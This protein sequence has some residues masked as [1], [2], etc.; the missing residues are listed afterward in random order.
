MKIE[1]TALINRSQGFGQFSEQVLEE[2]IATILRV[3]ISN[4][5]CTTRGIR[6]S[7]QMAYQC[8]DTLKD[9]QVSVLSCS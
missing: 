7:R 4:M 3:E 6:V 9:S 5:L 1:K 2:P 8:K